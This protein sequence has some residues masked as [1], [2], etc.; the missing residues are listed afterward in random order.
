MLEQTID[1]SNHRIAENRATH[2]ELFYSLNAK[3]EKMEKKR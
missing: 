2:P 3:F 1:Y